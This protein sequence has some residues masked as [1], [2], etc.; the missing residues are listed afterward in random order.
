MPWARDSIAWT[1]KERQDRQRERQQQHLARIGGPADLTPGRAQQHDSQ[2]GPEHA[3]LHGDI[4]DAAA[5]DERKGYRHPILASVC[6]TVGKPFSAFQITL[7]ANR[8]S[9]ISRRHDATPALE[10]VPGLVADHGV[11]GKMQR[12]GV[13]HRLLGEQA[14]ADGDTEQDGEAPCSA[15]SPA[16]PR[17]KARSLQ[18]RTRGT[19]VVISSEEYDTPGSVANTMADQNPT[20]GRRARVPSR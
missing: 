1:A 15:A 8:A 16:S 10:R 4:V 12:N 19:S 14:E 18:N 6:L 9:A 13:D 5:T 11:T 20:R 2:D 7:G 3:E 17:R